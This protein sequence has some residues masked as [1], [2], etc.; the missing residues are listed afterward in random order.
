MELVEVLPVP[1]GKLCERLSYLENGLFLGKCHAEGGQGE[2]QAKARK[3]DT[4]LP[5]RTKRL[6]CQAAELGG[7]IVGK[8]ALQLNTITK[9]VKLSVV[10]DE[11][12]GLTAGGV[13]L[14][15][16]VGRLH[17][18]EGTQCREGSAEFDP[19]VTLGVFAKG[20]SKERVL[21]FPGSSRLA[22]PSKGNSG[23]RDL[24]G[25]PAWR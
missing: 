13:R 18:L 19:K 2:S 17:D 15:K 4:R 24:S 3:Q 14:G 16:G 7:R 8:A 1:P 9:E 12:Q 22:P 5:G 10:S 23:P 21:L 25:S 11:G 20:P 6:G